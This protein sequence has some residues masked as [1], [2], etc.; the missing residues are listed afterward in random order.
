MTALV[1][2]MLAL[3]REKTG[4]L[5]V[6]EGTTGMTTIISTGVTLD[7]W[8]GGTAGQYIQPHTPLTTGR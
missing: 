2:A 4:G 6:L 8:D 3:S 5:I 7:G 1:R